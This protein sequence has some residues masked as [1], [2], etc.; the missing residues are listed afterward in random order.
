MTVNDAKIQEA[1]MFSAARPIAAGAK[2]PPLHRVIT[3][4]ERGGQWYVG[5]PGVESS[6]AVTIKDLRVLQRVLTVTYKHYRLLY[7][8]TRRE[9]AERVKMAEDYAERE[10]LTTKRVL[11]TPK[12]AKPKLSLTTSSKETS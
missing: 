3:L 9:R 2:L 4:E 10:G 12:Q 11:E 1:M 6:D 5:Y 7:N 8:T